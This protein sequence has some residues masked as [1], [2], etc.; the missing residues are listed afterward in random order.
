MTVDVLAVGAHPDDAELG[1][2]GLLHKLSSQGYRVGIL[3]LTMG[4]RSTRGTPEERAK[5]ARRAAEILGVSRRETAR[6]PDGGLMNARDQQQQVIRLLRSFRPRIILSHMHTD[7]HPDHRNACALVRDCNFL[8]GLT[9]QVTEDEP[10]R[11]Q[12][13]YYYRPYYED[14]TEPHMIIDTSEHFEAKLEAL[15]AYASQFYNPKYRGEETYVSSKSFW[16][17]IQTRA[18]YWGHRIGVTYGEPLFADGPF[19]LQYPPGLEPTA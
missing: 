14:A 7:R 19:G 3:D 13:L 18:A 2:G 5:E 11:A 4:E 9:H 17:A 8:A 1:V 6:L 16:D 12:Y 15:R 10:Y